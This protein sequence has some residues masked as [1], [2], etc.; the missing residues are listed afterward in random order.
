[1]IQQLY[2]EDVDLLQLI[3]DKL[4]VP[5]ELITQILG[6][7]ALENAKLVILYNVESGA[8]GL[9]LYDG[10]YLV[11][12]LRMEKIDPLPA[13]PLP[14]LNP[15][16]PIPSLGWKYPTIPYC[17]CRARC[18]CRKYP[19]LTLIACS[20]P[21]GDISGV[22]TPYTLYSNEQLHFFLDI[23][24]IYK[25]IE[26]VDGELYREIEKVMKFEI[27]KNDI[28]QIGFIPQK[29]PIIC[30]WISMCL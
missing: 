1:M 21:L 28:L 20:R 15:L 6:D 9:D 8:I 27:Y 22:N 14:I 25:Y 23:M 10:D 18:P 11:F 30:L 7:Q 29:T 13:T 16:I 2:G 4:E 17:R 19:K 26:G 3:A 12:E 24:Q 5:R